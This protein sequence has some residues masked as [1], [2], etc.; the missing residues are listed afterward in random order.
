MMVH[1]DDNLIAV[2]QNSDGSFTVRYVGVVPTEAEAPAE[3]EDYVTVSFD[4]ETNKFTISVVDLPVIN[5]SGITTS[6]NTFIHPKNHS[7]DSSL[8]F[9]KPASPESIILLVSTP[10]DYADFLANA[11]K[12]TL[13]WTG[14][15]ASSDSSTLSRNLGSTAYGNAFAT[16]TINSDGSSSV[17][18]D[19]AVPVANG[20]VIKQP[21][22]VV[23]TASNKIRLVNALNISNYEISIQGPVSG[24]ASGPEITYTT[25]FNDEIIF[26]WAGGTVE[27][28]SNTHI[29]TL[30][31]KS[32]YTEYVKIGKVTIDS[33]NR[34]KASEFYNHGASFLGPAFGTTGTWI[35]GRFTFRN[36]LLINHT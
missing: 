20:P 1:G 6:F 28:V 34:T 4:S 35:G 13:F 22:L 2:D 7:F 23:D 30:A 26:G 24:A 5:V 12:T 9:D 29:D 10:K 33:N 14:F 18:M 32:D 25:P 17:S 36:G 19:S 8:V 27:G 15:A 16:V 31:N 11:N 3:D 21:A